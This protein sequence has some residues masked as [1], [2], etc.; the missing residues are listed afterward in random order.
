SPP[1]TKSDI[2]ELIARNR[3]YAGPIAKMLANA[4]DLQKFHYAFVLRNARVGWTVEQ[5]KYYFTWLSELRQKSGGNSFQGFINCADRDAL[6]NPPD[7]DRLA[8]EAAGVRKPYR[9]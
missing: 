6:E 4:P 9:P 5:K 1:P 8:V 7:G 2:D 3:G